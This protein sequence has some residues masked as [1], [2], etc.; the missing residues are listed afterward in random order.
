M[1]ARQSKQKINLLKNICEQPRLGL[2][3]TQ[4]RSSFYYKYKH[5]P[6]KA[7]NPSF[8]YIEAVKS[9]FGPKGVEF[10]REEAKR[11]IKRPFKTSIPK[12]LNLEFN[13]VEIF[14]DFDSDESIKAWK[15]VADSDT[16]NGFS[17]SYF[18]RSQA[19]HGLFKGVIDTRIPDDGV[20][21]HSGM[22]GIIGP[23]APRKSLTAVESHWNWT[24]YNAFDIKFRGDGRKYNVVLNTATYTSDIEFYDTHVYPLYT[25]GG[26]Y[27]Q[28]VRIPFSKFIFAH[29][30]FIQDEQGSFP[31]NRVKFVS[32]TLE[33][34]VSGPF[35][36]EIDHMGLVREHRPFDEVTAYEGYTFPHI[37]YRPVSVGCAPP[38][39]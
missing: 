25:R 37:K 38:E 11:I 16:S 12:T 30:C 28:T 3:L 32:I 9:F 19:G 23:A 34:T 14:E 27:W 13:Q 18:V 15:P 5:G 17:E 31:A 4:T 39:Q 22:A 26:P 10:V 29:Q 6:T 24:L 7:S 20:T 33:D 8:D 21:M 36:L 1:F 2:N 35:E